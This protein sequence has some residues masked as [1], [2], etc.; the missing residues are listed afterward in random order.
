MFGAKLKGV[1]NA[2]MSRVSEE[3]QLWRFS[4]EQYHQ[5]VRSGILTENDPVEL[6]QGWVVTKMSKNPP[7]SSTMRLIRKALDR[8]VPEGW[9]VD[10][11]EPITTA[12]SEPEPD[13]A[14]LRG[15]EQSYIQRHPGPSD[16]CI[17]IE[18]ADSTLKNDQGLKLEIYAQA[19]IGEY[20]IVNL[21][22]RR[23]EVYTQPQ[24]KTYQ[25]R[26]IY[27]Q[28]MAVPVNLDGRVVG[29]IQVQ[30]LLP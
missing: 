19:A 5:M 13:F 1:Y 7:H 21:V 6:L 15:S 12:D 29:H 11:Q 20:W 10:I 27:D 24:G 16:V 2:P 9:Y 3:T 17:V 28:T 14:I 26:T 4:V 23:L 8:L 22:D 18:V 30:D 25:T